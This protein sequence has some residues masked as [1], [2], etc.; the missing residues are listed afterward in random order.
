[1]QALDGGRLDASFRLPDVETLLC[2]VQRAGDP[3]ASQV[4]AHIVV[5]VS[6]S[7]FPV[8]PDGAS[9]GSLIHLQEPPVR[10]NG[11]GNRGQRRESWT[12]HLRRLVPTGACLVGPLAVVVGKERLG[13]LRDL[14]ERVWPVD[15][16]AL[17]TK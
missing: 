13:E 8:G 17:L 10:I 14:Q 16:Q 12:S 4:S 6:G 2:S 3:L 7:E 15:L 9:K 5:M 1:M 11:L